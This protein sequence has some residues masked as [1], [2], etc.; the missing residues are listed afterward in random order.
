MLAYCPDTQL[1]KGQLLIKVATALT[2]AG[3]PSQ[4]GEVERPIEERFSGDTV[5]VGGRQTTAGEELRGWCPA[6]SETI[7]RSR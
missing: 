4:L 1:S 7:Q 3:R 5:A 2:L 6:L